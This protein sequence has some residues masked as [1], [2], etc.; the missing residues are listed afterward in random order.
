MDEEF[1]F[2][3]QPKDVPKVSTKHRKICTKLPVPE[4]MEIIERSVKYEPWSMNNQLYAVWDKAVDY[5]IFDKW[6]NIW[7]DF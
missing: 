1:Y 6:G 3:R 4:S 2:R 5:Q 7:I